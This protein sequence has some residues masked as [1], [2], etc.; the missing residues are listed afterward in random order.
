MLTAIAQTLTASIDEI[1]RTWVDDLRRNNRTEIHK[2]LLSAEIIDGVKGILAN[3]ARAIEAHEAPDDEELPDPPVLKAFSA[4]A[5]GSA[6]EKQRLTTTRPLVGPLSQAL[7]GAASLGRL[8]HSQG[9]DIQEVLY[10]Y[11]K[12]RQCLWQALQSALEFEELPVS[13]DVTAYV[14]RLLDELMLTAVENFYNTSV[15][16]L[17]KR[18]VRDPLTELYNKDYFHQRLS[19]EMRRAIRYAEPLSVVMMD[20]DLLKSIN[21]AYG[22][23]AG[24]QAIRALSAVIQNTCRQTD[25]PCRY[26]GDEFAVILPETSREH[27]LAFAERVMKAVQSLSII[28]V[29]V[30][31]AQNQE[32]DAIADVRD[33]ITTGELESK[34][35]VFAPTPTISIGVASFPDDARNPEILLAKADAAL[36]K[37]KNE[38]RN[39]ISA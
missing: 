22:H 4:F 5:N 30:D 20:M 7:V 26:G 8:R 38:G 24:D 17:E 2:Q 34:A 13:A 29:P 27:A 16:D 14:D 12:L 6:A 11:V 15:S 33:R 1:T 37:A 18:A 28:L 25:V 32:G 9:Y 3:L 31:H 39:R 35:P 21:D 10:E 19:E 23:P 36:Y